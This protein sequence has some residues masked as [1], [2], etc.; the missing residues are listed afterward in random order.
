MNEFVYLAASNELPM[1]SFFDL[2]GVEDHFWQFLKAVLYFVSPLLLIWAATEIGG[3]LLGVIR[4][5]FTRNRK[6]DDDHDDYDYE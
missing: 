3:N 4:D 6:N 5:A 1:V 2:S